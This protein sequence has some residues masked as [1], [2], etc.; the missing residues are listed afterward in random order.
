MIASTSKKD[1]FKIGIVL[2]TLG[3][4]ILTSSNNVWVLC[5]FAII[6]TLGELIYSP[7]QNARRF[8]MIPNDQRSTYATFNMVSNNGAQILARFGLILGAFLAPWMMSIYVAAV[9]LIG[10]ILLYYA[11]FMNPNIDESS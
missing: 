3:Y 2:Y 7:I 9:V 4:A 1:V 11:L 10:F 5:L 8:L 6:A